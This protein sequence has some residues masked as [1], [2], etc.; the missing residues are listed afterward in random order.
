M[1][2]INCQ[3]RRIALVFVCA[4]TLLSISPTVTAEDDAGAKSPNIVVIMADDLG[5]GDIGC[6]GNKEIKT[7]HLDKLAAG[8]MRFTDFHSS[9]PVCSPTRAGLLT[10]RYQQR[11]GVPGVINAD[12]KVNRHHGLQLA[13]TTFAELLKPAG[14]RTGVMGK[15]HLGYDPKFNPRH[16]GFDVFR[17]YVSGN[18]DYISHY[19]R[20]E[21]Y[22]WWRDTE[23]VEEPGYSTH[24]IS[25]HAV[26]FLDENKDWPFC[27]YVAHEAPHSPFQRPGD[28]P[29]RGPKKAKE[30]LG[31]ERTARARREMIEEM[32]KG[33]GDVIAALERNGLRDNTLVLF[34]SDNGAERHGTNA[35]L[36][37]FKGS[38]WEGGHRVPAI[39]NWPGVVEPGTTCDATT[40]SLDVMPTMLDL[41]GVDAPKDRPLDG[42]S[43]MPL[44][45]QEEEARP[46]QLFWQFG[47]Q[48]AVRDGRWKLLMQGRK[49]PQLYDL[50]ADLG[51]T[52]DL[53]AKHPDRVKQ[54]K[55]AYDAWL[56]DVQ[57]GATEQP[58]K[59]ASE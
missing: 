47:T 41:V 13:E 43:L 27:L 42:H 52:T 12:P 32:D 33:V 53:A 30:K 55:A 11:A 23:L 35:P 36:N 8:G 57:T 2:L 29:Q 19:D 14:Y 58:E 10:G 5:Y 38:L 20:M 56:K 21:I 48:G 51:E 54:L 24:L 45:K 9:G 3:H 37:G 17:G 22:D 7:P 15:W 26:K 44:L 49:P 1:Q 40:I 59:S 46:R 25:K 4:I 50:S 6:Y 34:F 28:P 16:Q 31:P 18:I 39:A